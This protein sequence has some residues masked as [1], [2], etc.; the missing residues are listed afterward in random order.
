MR[1]ISLLPLLLLLNHTIA[2][3]II[4]TSIVPWLPGRLT[5]SGDHLFFISADD[6][7]SNGLWRTNGLVSETEPIGSTHEIS[8]ARSLIDYNGSLFFLCH[9]DEYGIELWKTSG[10][11]QNASLVKDLNPGDGGI[12]NNNDLHYIAAT[13]EGVIFTCNFNG[14]QVW[15]SDGTDEGT[16]LLLDECDAVHLFEWKNEVYFYQTN[17]PSGLYKTNGT[18]ATKTLIKNNATPVYINNFYQNLA[19]TEDYIFFI[20]ISYDGNGI[21]TGELWKSD[22]SPGGTE[23]VI[24]LEEKTFGG[25]QRRLW[26]NSNILFFV[27]YQDATGAE[28]WISDGTSGGTILL[29]DISGGDRSSFPKYFT[30]SNGMVYFIANKQLY[31]TDGTRQGTEKALIGSRDIDRLTSNEQ[32]IHFEDEDRVWQLNPESGISKKISTLT[33]PISF[34]DPVYF[35]NFLF[36]SDEGKLYK[37]DLTSLVGI[38]NSLDNSKNRFQ[39]YPNPFTNKVFIEN[40]SQLKNLGYS[41]EILSLDG[42]RKGSFSNMDSKKQSLNLEKLSPGLYIFNIKD[43]T[44]IATQMV[45]KTLK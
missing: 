18:P 31:K 34:D 24:A 32:L 6:N 13:T 14:P 44:G 41:V 12:I 15:F 37:F 9:T 11:G 5:A 35:K 40:S 43:P 17:P 33:G 27:G 7:T 29:S 42:K 4:H 28:P 23:K 16:T 30:E 19:S 8:G 2:Q 38:N 10:N 22:G 1:L 36:F 20:N 26:G 3:E 25:T 39:V 45:V 21:G